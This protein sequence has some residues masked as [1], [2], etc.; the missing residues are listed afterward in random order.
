MKPCSVNGTDGEPIYQMGLELF[1]EFLWK[2]PKVVRV[3]L[4]G[5]FYLRLFLLDLDIQLDNSPNQE[6][7][8]KEVQ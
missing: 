2:T 4:H 6:Y 8:Q 3:L 1:I 5:L 7:H